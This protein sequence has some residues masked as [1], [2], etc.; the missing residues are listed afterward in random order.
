MKSLLIRFASLVLLFNS[1]FVGFALA[2]PINLERTAKIDVTYESRLETV[3]ITT[4]DVIVR[5][6]D[7][8]SECKLVVA[9]GIMPCN[10]SATNSS[11]VKLEWEPRQLVDILASKQMVEMNDDILEK[12]LAQEEKRRA[13]PS[14]FYQTAQSTF[15][16]ATG[17]NNLRMLNETF[18][19][20]FR[21]DE[22]IVAVR[23]TAA[24]EAKS[25]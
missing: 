13:I 20:D 11:Y 3:H 10:L 22:L 25:H 8:L 24:V 23:F 5:Y 1:S 16:E 2:T 19:K 21:P 6:S 18:I 7:D 14:F 15:D 4:D 12:I 17:R 9:D